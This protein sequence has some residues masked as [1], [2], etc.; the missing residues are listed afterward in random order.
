MGIAR[1]PQVLWTRCH[2]AG[3]LMQGARCPPWS[4][5][6]EEGV[7]EVS[8]FQHATPGAA[9]PATRR[10]QGGKKCARVS[11]NH[12]GIGLKGTVPIL[13]MRKFGSQMLSH[14][15]QV[16]QPRSSQAIWTGA[17]GQLALSSSSYPLASWHQV[18]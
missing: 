15:L 1:F 11:P 4:T 3:C 14:L 7:P 2:R 17:G 5:V 18:G 13:Q 12:A 9:S 16:S 10:L 6:R 8:Q